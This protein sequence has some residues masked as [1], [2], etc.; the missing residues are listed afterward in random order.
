MNNTRFATAIHILTL[1]AHYPDE[2]LSS[3][4]IA[5]SININPVI[6]R[7]EL[8]VLK[9][10]GFIESK[11]GKDGGCRLAKNASE[12]AV[13]EIY[14]A[15]KNGDVL[16][17]KNQNPNPKCDVGRDINQNLQLLF[18]ETD[19]LIIQFLKQKSLADFALLFA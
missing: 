19:T 8:I 16:G 9:E 1:L 14:D 11:M 6:V 12:I 7:K 4:L 5:A 2:W 15:V 17:K 3:D 13:S 18:S 10:A